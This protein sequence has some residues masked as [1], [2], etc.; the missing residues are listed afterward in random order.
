MYQSSSETFQVTMDGAVVGTFTPSGSSYTAFGTHGFVVAAGIHTVAFVGL[1]PNGGDNT[2]FID[3]VSIVT[4]P[5]PPSTLQDGGFETPSIGSG[6]SAYVYN[7]PA[8]PW[9]FVGQAGVTGNNSGF[10][11]GNPAAPQGSQVAFLQNAGS[12]SQA[13]T[14]SAG[15]YLVSFSA[16]QRAAYQSSSQ[17]F[18]VRIDGVTVGTF[19][20]SS[21]SYASFAT[22]TVNL[23][24]GIHTVAFV[25]LNP[26][27]GDNTAFIDQVAIS[28]PPPGATVLVART[29]PGPGGR[30]FQH[31]PDV[32]EAVASV[33]ATWFLATEDQVAM[34]RRRRS[35]GVPGH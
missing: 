28:S 31:L 24:A 9:T 13:V 22:S 32:R 33:F 27:G 25:G 11:S 10:T 20:P 6:P 30:S 26:N 18:Q 17:T 5:P 3:Q 34:N 29:I 14:L 4:A 15:T 8:S 1:N 21:T 19:T 7:P 12:F 35:A 16:A 2:A 23:T